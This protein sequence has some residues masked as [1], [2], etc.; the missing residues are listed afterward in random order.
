MRILLVNWHLKIGG[1]ESYVCRLAAGLTARGHAV[2]L[3]TEGG[4][5]EDLAVRSGAKLLK[6]GSLKRDWPHFATQLRG[7]KFQLAH[8]HNY[9]SA[10]TGRRVAAALGIP[11]LMSVHGPRPRPKQLLF[12]DWS[13]EVV[14]MSEGDRG[15]VRWWGG[16]GARPVALSFYG[17]DAAR[18]RPGLDSAA[19]RR[20]LGLADDAIPIAFIS[21]FSN[22]KAKVGHALLAALPELVRRAPRL[23]LLLVGEGPEMGALTRQVDRI[24]AA[25]GRPVATM[26]GPRRDVEAVMSLAAVCICAANTA[27]ESLAC[28]AP[29]IAAG[30]TGFFGP[31]WR[32]N[33]ALARATCFADHGIAPHRLSSHALAKALGE[34]LGD[35]PEARRRALQASE[36]VRQSCGIEAM[37]ADMEAIYERQLALR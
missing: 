23:R 21:R 10:R 32:E 31:V 14:A 3:L 25:H 20:E 35:L 34:L 11:Y 5:F 18:F 17:I 13:R 27:I 8:A 33:F 37:A 24:N 22:R 30:R 2:S 29:T 9:Q 7:A 6:V 28:A 19:L 1:V 26:V 4:P 15:N 36:L 12:R 16:A